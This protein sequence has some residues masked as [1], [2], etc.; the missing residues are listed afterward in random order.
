MID[1]SFLRELDRFNLIIR[2]KVTSSYSGE[3]TSVAYGK[4]L[5][6]KDFQPYTPGDD[7]RAIDWKVYART[8]GLFIRRYEED[9]NITV[10]IILDA[11]ASMDYGTPTRKFDY[12]SM[13]GLGFLYMALKN[14]ENFE[15]TTFSEK[16]NPFR[17]RK[18]MKQ[19]AE[20]IDYLNS[21]DVKGKSDF[22]DSLRSYKK[23]I[24]S[25]SLIIII[26]DFL[27][28]VDE[29]KNTLKRFRRSE[30]MVVQV[31]DPAERHIS[32][33]GDTILE[34]SETKNVIRTYLSNRTINEYQ[35]RLESHI[36]EMDEL[37]KKL[38][39]KFISVTTNQ[40]I[41]DIFYT[42]MR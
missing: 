24:H 13:I 23:M 9:R 5:V 12:G 21:M 35:D 26:S 20:V 33:H 8:E 2:K 19:L 31:L 18:G 1:L 32:L 17:A 16:L 41:F 38:N 36:F 37:C 34:D 4:G 42:L 25:K 15:F 27:F 7:F 28:D 10:R 22:E 29:L 6:F 3:R 11:S 39:A 40:P 30:V 14:N